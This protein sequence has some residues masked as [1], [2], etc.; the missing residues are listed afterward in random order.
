MDTVYLLW[1]HN[2]VDEPDFLGAYCSREAAQKTYEAMRVEKPWY[3]PA[4]MAVQA[5][6]VVG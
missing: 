3:Y 5:Y 2:N 4:Y 1:Y 6:D